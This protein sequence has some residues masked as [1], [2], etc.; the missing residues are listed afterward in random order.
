ML[1]ITRAVVG[2]ERRS[3][4]YRERP[5]TTTATFVPSDRGHERSRDNAAVADGSPFTGRM[6]SSEAQASARSR[7]T[8]R[9]GD[10]MG[11]EQFQTQ[12]GSIPAL[13]LHT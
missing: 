11:Q 9:K 10:N 6:R 4:T 3:T 12:K 1:H 8:F 2:S 7:Q 5:S 13:T